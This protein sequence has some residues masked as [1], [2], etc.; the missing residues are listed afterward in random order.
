MTNARAYAPPHFHFDRFATRAKQVKNK[1]VVN[2]VVSEA[3]ALKRM[4]KQIGL[5][6]DQLAEK[7]RK[8]TS[9]KGGL[10]HYRPVTEK[11]K[12]LGN[13][14]RTWAFLSQ[15]SS[16][17]LAL[18]KPPKLNESDEKVGTAPF[19]PLPKSIFGHAIEYTDD[20][21]EEF[22]NGS[23]DAPM[24]SARLPTPSLKLTRSKPSM[25]KTPKSI[26]QKLV[27]L[28]RCVEE[29][30]SASSTPMAS[31]IGIDKNKQ[32]QELV[33]ELEELRHFHQTEAEVL[34]AET[35]EFEK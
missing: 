25:L 17:C 21:F 26:R 12:L 33:E 23:L 7:E 31:P 13:R 2:E 35:K 11:K 24:A 27:G 10:F 28:S 30:R 20:G 14:R 29:A 34:Q 8:L 19:S 5:L 1:P 22:L 4:K 16:D 32:V 9:L 6:E 15:E 18:E 3:V